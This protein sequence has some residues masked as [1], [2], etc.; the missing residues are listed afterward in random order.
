[1]KRPFRHHDS[2]LACDGLPLRGL[3]EEFGTPLFVYSADHIRASWRAIARAFRA[4]KPAIAY[5]VK[6]NTNAAILALLRDEGA[7]FDIVS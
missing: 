4:A 3:A 6:A 5:S 7:F 1:M 2:E